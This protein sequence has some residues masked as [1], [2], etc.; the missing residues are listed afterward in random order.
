MKPSEHIQSL[1]DRV[2]LGES[3]DWAAESDAMALEQVGSDA[4][5]AERIKEQHTRKLEGLS[6]VGYRRSEAQPDGGGEGS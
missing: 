2:R 3:I 4:Q 1:A 5:F 6:R